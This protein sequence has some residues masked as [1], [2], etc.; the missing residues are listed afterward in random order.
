MLQKTQLVGDFCEIDQKLYVKQN[1]PLAYYTLRRD[2]KCAQQKNANDPTMLLKTKGKKK[3][4]GLS[5]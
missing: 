5:T 1:K 2:G 4:C 3:A